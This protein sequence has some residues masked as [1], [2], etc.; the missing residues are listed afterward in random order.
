ML[1]II[2][3]VINEFKIKSTDKF[4]EELISFLST[5]DGIQNNTTK[6][7]F[8]EDFSLPKSKELMKFFNDL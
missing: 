4:E 3:D 5:N 2:E 8:L 1:D 7:E 6:E